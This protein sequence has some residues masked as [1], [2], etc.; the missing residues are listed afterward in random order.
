M[1][2]LRELSLQQSVKVDHRQRVAAVLSESNEM[3]SRSWNGVAT[4]VPNHSHHVC[5]GQGTGEAA[6]SY[7]QKA[8][9]PD[10]SLHISPV[11]VADRSRQLLRYAGEVCLPEP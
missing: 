7:E 6:G 4:Q 3:G 8:S 10:I 1:A 2:S 11:F 9:M 5:C